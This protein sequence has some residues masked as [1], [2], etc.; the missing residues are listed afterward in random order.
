MLD[1]PHETT[2]IVPYSGIQFLVYE[3]D[4]DKTPQFSRSFIEHRGTG[5]AAADGTVAV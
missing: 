3:I 4:I 2:K 5:P 1:K